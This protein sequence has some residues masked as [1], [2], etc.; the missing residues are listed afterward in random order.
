[1]EEKQRHGRLH[2]TGRAEPCPNQTK[3]VEIMMTPSKSKSDLRGKPALSMAMAM[4][5]T[6]ITPIAVDVVFSPVAQAAQPL[7]SPSQQVSYRDLD[8]ATSEGVAKLHLR[9]KR[10]AKHVC[11]INDWPFPPR[12]RVG[13]ECVAAATRDAMQQA[14]RRIAIY[15]AQRLAVD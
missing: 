3:E 2:K 12:R 15:R 14:E 8:L 11:G 7:H 10:A 13:R 5:A 6:C 4:F 9:I 1:M